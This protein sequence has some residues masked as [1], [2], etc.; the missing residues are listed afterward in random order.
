LL[1]ATAVVQ[2]GLVAMSAP[3]AHADGH[4]LPGNEGDVGV[5]TN[6]ESHVMEIGE[7]VYGNTGNVAEQLEPGVP[8]TA[9]SM[10][11]SIFEEDLANGGTDY[12]LD[13]VLGVRGSLG[14]NVL[15][16]RGRSLYMRGA[17]NNNF[18]VMGFAGNAFAGG[19]N[20]LGNFYTVTVP[21]QTVTENN[22]NRF[23]APS[24]MSST[25]TIGDTGV[26]A[27]LT[28]FI[29]TTTSPSRGSRSTTRVDR[30]APSRCVRR[31]RSPS[32][33]PTPTTSSPAPARSPAAP[34]T[35][36]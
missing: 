6:G 20:N 31:P 24:H 13:R 17:S 11:Q 34:T 5:Y 32:S 26:S 12:Y 30:R 16:T 14:A 33:P 29:T 1:A 8:F 15:Q 27:D 3:T 25:Y 23:N 18:S 35:D 19:P 10:H 36:S 7:P 22:A 9:D 21:G 4:V 28:R 2:G